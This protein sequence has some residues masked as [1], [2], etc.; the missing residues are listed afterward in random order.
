ME[1]KIGMKYMKLKQAGIGIV[2]AIMFMGC[3]STEKAVTK[4]VTEITDKRAV[5]ERVET[6]ERV[7]QTTEVEEKQDTEVVQPVQ[8]ETEQ[9]EQVS[10]AMA[11]PAQSVEPEYTVVPMDVQVMYVQQTLNL[12]NGAGT[13]YEK[14]GSLAQ[15]EQ[16]VVN[17]YVDTANGKWYQLQNDD[18]SIKGFV[19]ASYVGTSKVEIKK[20]TPKKTTTSNNSASS[21]SSKNSSSSSN[22]NSSSSNSNS[23]NNSSNSSSTPTES[24]SSDDGA[25]V[26][27]ATGDGSGSSRENR[28]Y[29]NENW[30]ADGGIG[31][32]NLQ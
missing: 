17:G 29:S 6:T 13:D 7:E 22:N 21:G 26:T 23:S 18:G 12:R 8:T 19:S 11:E 5:T 10:G 2:C 31:G 4:D 27:G 3:G 14:I 32:G 1:E 24:V 20:P 16:I 30:G 15:N 9:S 28:S 25:T